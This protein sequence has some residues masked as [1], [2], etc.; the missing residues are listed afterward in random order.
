MKQQ[1]KRPPKPKQQQQQTQRTT[2]LTKNSGSRVAGKENTADQNKVSEPN[3]QHT[4]KQMQNAPQ[5]KDQT[6]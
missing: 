2:V 5:D 3:L 4:A 1:N 6:S